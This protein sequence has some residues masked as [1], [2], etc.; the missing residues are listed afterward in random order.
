ML[1]P[2]LLP[3][4]YDN[5]IH[6]LGNIGIGGKIHSE[7]SPFSTKVIN[8]LRYNNVDIRKEILSDYSK[9][10]IL[11]LCCGTGMSTMEKCT[12]IDTSPEMLN[13]ANKYFPNKKFCQCL[14]G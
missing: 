3:Y 4:Y 5:R 10:D 8:Y 9:Y 7:L 12:G 13:V 14:C 1:V 2:S 6:S 11:D